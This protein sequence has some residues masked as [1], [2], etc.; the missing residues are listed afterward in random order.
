MDRFAESAQER[1]AALALRRDL[2]DP[3]KVSENLRGL[4]RCL[5]RLC[6]GE[7]CERAAHEALQLMSGEPASAEAAWA[8]AHYAA[9]IGDT[10]P[11]GHALSVAR[12][13]CSWRRP[14]TAPRPSPTASTPSER[15]RSG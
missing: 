2:G 6:R 10:H 7:E 14:S 11:R 15:W 9:L 13:G 5:W 3:V 1:E 8:H 4:A 12:R